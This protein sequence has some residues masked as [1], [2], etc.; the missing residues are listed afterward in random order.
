[1]QT[2]IYDYVT[3]YAKS[4]P[5]RFHMPAHK[6]APVLGC[7]PLDIT[8][9]DGADDLYHADG[10]I[11]QSEQ[12]ATA[13]F[14]SAHTFYATGGSSQS[15]RAMLHLALQGKENPVVLA[16]RNA[17]KAFLYA[18]ALLDFSVEW[19]CSA[20]QSLCACPIT[21]EDLQ[22]ALT[23][24]QGKIHA[25][26]VTSPDYLGNMLDIRALSAVCR[27]HAVPLLVD[28]AHG[29]YLHFL[30]TSQ[31]P[32]HLGAT[33][34]CDS[35]HK[36]L[37]VLTGGGYLHI[38][39]QATQYMPYARQSLALFGSTSPSYLAL[40]SL[41]LC[42]A[43]LEKYPALLTQTMAQIQSC[44]TQLV[45]QGWTICDSEPLKITL[46]TAASG[47]TGGQVAAHLQAANLY[48]EYADDSYVVLMCA[49]EN[50]ATAYVKLTATLAKL[51]QNPALAAVK[52]TTATMPAAACSI[53]K[54][55][56]GAQEM[57]PVALAVGRICAAPVVSCPPAIPIAVSGE[58]IGQQ[59]IALFLQYGIEQVAVVLSL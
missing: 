29:A 11:L 47:Y 46:Q 8:E 14:G 28:N 3:A 33:M 42:N 12:H 48:V 6:G 50:P 35:A 5:V 55:L 27:A 36:T 56:L 59:E 23:R 34:C 53:R 26:Y 54:A 15:I 24:A 19:L 38:S 51:P 16:G 21:A 9:I 31:H 44:K 10:I 40:Q 20:S 52:V 41:D 1:M 13:H 7:E 49:P 18:A 22:Q 32:L 4:A 39:P 37:P 43:Y 58:I 57:V 25:V 17:H 2:P 45:A 30:P